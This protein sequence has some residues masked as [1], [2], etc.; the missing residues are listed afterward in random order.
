MSVVAVL[1][2]D[3]QPGALTSQAISTT[4]NG[5]VAKHALRAQWLLRHLLEVR[6]FDATAFDAFG[7][8]LH[9]FHDRPNVRDVFDFVCVGWVEN[10]PDVFVVS[11]PQAVAGASAPYSSLLSM[12]SAPDGQ[13]QREFNL[14]GVARGFR[15]LAAT[16]AAGALPGIL[17]VANPAA[18]EGNGV[19][20][21]G[22][23]VGAGSGRGTS[24]GR[25]KAKRRR[26]AGPRQSRPG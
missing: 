18:P 15:D 24:A 8:A 9:R 16:A 12:A 10:S 22:P 26:G 23:A 25:A 2:F 14:K 21:S 5:L 1:S 17:L 7:V 19:G 6:F 4:V 11:R 13:L 3:I 20:G